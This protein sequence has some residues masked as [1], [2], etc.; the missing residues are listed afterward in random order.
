VPHTVLS[1]DQDAHEA[2]VVAAAGKPAT[3]TVAT[4]MAGRGTD[5][6]LAPE[7]VAAGGLHIIVSELNDAGRIDRQLAGRA[8]RQ[9]DPGSVEYC[10]SA[11]DPVTEG[12]GA[13]DPLVA[14]LLRT[15]A[16]QRLPR[17]VAFR[18]LRRAQR[19]LELVHARTRR[20]QLRADRLR[21][22]AMAFTGRA[23]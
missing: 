18:V 11:N 19:H 12:A 4:N 14:A 6:A 10:L 8:A 2:E 13:G 3:V 1:A 17:A 9:G 16:L 21:S 5:I 22:K 15:G 20:A 7:A 23:E